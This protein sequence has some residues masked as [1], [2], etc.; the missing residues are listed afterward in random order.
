MAEEPAREFIESGLDLA[1]SAQIT[2]RS[3]ERIKPALK[4][5]PIWELATAQLDQALRDLEGKA[6]QGRAKAKE[7]AQWYKEQNAIYQYFA[8]MARGV[9]RRQRQ[10]D[11][12]DLPDESEDYL[13][14]RPVK[15]EPEEEPDGE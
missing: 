13:R 10:R 9:S 8:R 2:F 1:Q 14:G 12:P 11:Q 15:P 3:I 6:A 7:S 5:H 4:G